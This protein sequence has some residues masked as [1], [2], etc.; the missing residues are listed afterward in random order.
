[1]EEKANK[2]PFW[3][4]VRSFIELAGEI[5]ELVM[6][7]RDKPS[8]LDWISIGFRGADI[9]IRAADEYKEM[10]ADEAPSF[11]EEMDEETGQSVWLFVPAEFHTFVM[12]EVREAEVLKSHWDGQ[13]NSPRVCMGKVGDEVVAWLAKSA[14]LGDVAQGPYVKRARSEETYLAVGQSIWKGL[15]SRHCVFVGGEFQVDEFDL[16]S[17]LPTAQFDAIEHRCRAFLEKGI[18]R[19]V[20]FQGPPGTGKSLGVRH[21]V[22]ALGMNSVRVDLSTIEGKGGG[23]LISLLE[24]LLKLMRPDVLLLDDFDHVEAEGRMLHF[25]EAAN[26]LCRLVLVTVNDPGKLTEAMLRPGR[27]DDRFVVD[28]LDRNVLFKMVED[29]SVLDMMETLP[30]AYVT[31][32]KKRR[33]ALGPEQAAREIPELVRRAIRQGAARPSKPLPEIEKG[34]DLG[35]FGGSGYDKDDD[36]DVDHYDE[37]PDDVPEVTLR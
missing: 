8:A 5:G 14:M 11:F 26:R 21:L 31:E 6:S 13:Q 29:D 37:D 4:R 32:F 35:F 23:G 24:T 30:V 9:V 33:A 22:K 25:W 10:T 28:R 1:M 20:L 18:H 12:K 27:F 16:G 36:W 15:A 7:L 34:G 2:V 19:S 17:F 3:Q